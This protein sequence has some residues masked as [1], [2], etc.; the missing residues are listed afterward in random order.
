M[1][2]NQAILIKSGEKPDAT[3]TFTLSETHW[4]RVKWLDNC[5]STKFL[6]N[7]STSLERVISFNWVFY[8]LC[9]PMS[10][11]WGVWGV[12]WP[13]PCRPHCLCRVCCIFQWSDMVMGKAESWG[14][15]DVTCLNI[16]RCLPL[17]WSIKHI[18]HKSDIVTSQFSSCRPRSRKIVLS[19][20]IRNQRFNISD[21]EASLYCTEAQKWFV[22]KQSLNL[23]ITI[24]S[25]IN[26]LFWYNTTQNISEDKFQLDLQS[27]GTSL[28]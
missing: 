23:L 6:N 2:V 4:V 18:K 9:P 25:S 14:P 3:D 22:L 26:T 7:L 27:I 11:K 10:C 5:R 20:N 21:H 1:W 19:F 8:L 15:G 28:E 13:P 12:M 24:I 17:T 16:T